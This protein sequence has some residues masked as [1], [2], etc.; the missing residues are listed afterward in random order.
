MNK[1]VT[2]RISASLTGP[3]IAIASLTVFSPLIEGGTTQ[4]P[5]LVIRLILLVALGT[6]LVTG[7][8]RSKIC[9]PRTVLWW[10]IVALLGWSGLSLLWSPYTSVS[11]QWVL[12]L[13]L[14]AVFFL[15][16]LLGADSEKRIRGFLFFILL[17][18]LFEGGL[19]I[20]QYLSGS[21]PRAKGTFFN[22]NFFSTYESASVVLAVSLLLFQVEHGKTVKLFLILTAIVSGIAVILAQSRG[23]AAGFLI[24]LTVVGYVRYGKSTLILL[25]LLTLGTIL[26]PNPL[27]QR[28][29]DVG[30]QDPYAYTRVEIWED[31]TK[32]LYDH[33]MGIGL[34]M[35]KYASFQY[36]F[37]IEENI[38]RYGK[39][40]ETAHNEYLQLAVELGVMG[41]ALFL[42]SIVIWAAEIKRVW[43]T[44]L[45]QQSRGILVGLCAGVL[46]TIAHASVDSLFHEP[47]LVL[48]LILEGGLAVAF[49]RH[50]R[51]IQ[52]EQWWFSPTYHFSRVML[53]VVALGAM[54]SLAIQPASAWLF[55]NQG[56]SAQA[57]HDNV[58]AIKW[59]RYASIADPGSTAVRD[60]L[61]RLCIQRFRETGVPE[62]LDQAASEMAVAMA[63]NPLDGRPP[64][65]LGTIY[66]MQ[67]EQQA[68]AAHKIS[69]NAEAAQA[70][71][72]SISVD[73]FSP[74]GYFELSNLYRRN[75]DRT[76][77]QQLLE[78]ALSYEPNFIP[79]RMMLVDLAQEIGHTDVASMHLKVIETI[80][81]KY[82][83]WTLSPLEQQFLG[84]QP[85]KS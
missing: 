19:G 77:A 8:Y 18:G 51:G 29:T 32:R 54:T 36:R 47:A 62:W 80:R 60:G 23:G 61:A 71:E 41:L 55:V 40:A 82:Q 7:L 27:K 39:R 10:P 84:I 66:L 44:D 73:P 59:Y 43:K 58:S 67:A 37:P 28:M 52:T 56:N 17:M 9:I 75:G 24:A 31:A 12:S 16:I 30:K 21:E 6:W 78:R 34:G 53:I 46:A 65:R 1:F 49:G 11:L 26:F 22:P 63:L 48:L 3:C 69:L 68:W 74:F 76:A 25:F 72:K 83:D 64:Y 70:F 45:P 81:W 14:Y 85:P 50:V 33:P 38:I 35:Y 15:L 57:N 4:I 2:E 20:I 42:V 5:V 13:L 79:A